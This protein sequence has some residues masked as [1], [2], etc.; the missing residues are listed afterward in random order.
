MP[1][2]SGL[3][4][5]AT[6]RDSAQDHIDQRMAQHRQTDA[7]EQLAIRKCYASGMSQNEIAQQF[8]LA[9]SS[10]SRI[11]HKLESTVNDASEYA[12]SKALA[13]VEKAIANCDVDQALEMIDR[14]QIEGLTKREKASTPAVA[15]VVGSGSFYGLPQAEPMAVST[16]SL[17]DRV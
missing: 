5:T 4:R 15:I 1:N 7:T 13:L 2:V 10:I 9:Q 16:H 6:M 3:T 12:R 14:L 8:N 11:L 17:P